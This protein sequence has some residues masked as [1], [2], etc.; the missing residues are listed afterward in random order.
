ME[1]RFLPGILAY[2]F[3]HGKLRAELQGE[4]SLHDI[5]RSISAI[6]HYFFHICIPKRNTGR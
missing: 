6:C 4:N 3:H 2:L 1:G 5:C